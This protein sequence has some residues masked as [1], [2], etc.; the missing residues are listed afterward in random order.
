MSLLQTVENHLGSID[1][2]PVS[3]NYLFAETPSPPVVEELVAFFV[4]NGLP[5]TLAY[6]LYRTCNP[7]ATNE[8]LRQLFY[9][10]YSLW[11]TSD[12]VRRLTSYY[13]VCIKNKKKYSPDFLDDDRE[14]PVSVPGLRAPRL[15]F[16]NTATPTLINTML[17]LVR[18]V[19]L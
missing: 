7:P 14:N 4:G 18:Q 5:L 13:D 17:E 2:W 19:Q 11:H 9:T 8:L 16:H 10:R 3:I 1:T 12:S 6:R 15:G